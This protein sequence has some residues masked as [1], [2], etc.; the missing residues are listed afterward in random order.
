MHFLVINVFFAPNTYGGATIVAEEVAKSLV[1]EHGHRVSAISAI[2]RPDL[3]PYAVLK[4]AV[5]GIENYQINLPH[6]RPPTALY[7]NP[8]VS[9]RILRIATQIAPD[10]VHVHCIQD[11]GADCL[12][13]LKSAGFPVVLSVHDFWWIC[14]R[15][16][17]IRPNGRYCGQSPVK[18]SACRGCVDD[19]DATRA[20]NQMLASMSEAA[21]LITYPSQF[22]KDLSEASGFGLGRGMV[23]ENGIRPP[24]RAFFENQAARRAKD[25][26]LVFGFVG[27][28]SRIKGWPLIHQAFAGLGRSDF[29]GWLV[30]GSRD[31][32]WWDTVDFSAMKGEWAVHPRFEQDSMDAFYARIDVLL[33][34]S[35]WKETFGLT[36]REALSRGIKVI[37]T[38][39]G[40]T[41]E[42]GATEGVK[43]LPM[44]GQSG[45]EASG[46]HASGADRNERNCTLC[47]S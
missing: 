27:G 35:Q 34:M 30:E 17:M 37:Q 46:R 36:I 29:K 20:R 24:S 15:Q 44:G 5:D 39:S 32:S 21:D 3:E 2:S 1:K 28:P 47:R 38:D 25:D 41:T 43:I 9:A 45:A 11:I 18:T 6:G 19:F 8:E 13:A 4:C 7:Q 42:H 26:R 31:G 12:P 33:F 10:L 23:L 16:F 40:G 22:A 14:A